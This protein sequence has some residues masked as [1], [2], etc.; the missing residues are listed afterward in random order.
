MLKFI[1][2]FLREK[3]IFISS[4]YSEQLALNIHIWHSFGS[5]NFSPD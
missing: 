2:I 5:I 1:E 4:E 3:P